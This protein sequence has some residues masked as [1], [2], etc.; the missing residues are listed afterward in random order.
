MSETGHVTIAFGKLPMEAEFYCYG[1]I[2]LNYDSP[3]WCQCVKDGLWSAHEVDG[4]K[5]TMDPRSEV[6]IKKG[7]GQ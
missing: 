3:V 4:I 2:Y 5:F 7:A 1:D 6:F